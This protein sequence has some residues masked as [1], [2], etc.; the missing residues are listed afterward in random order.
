MSSR[1]RKTFIITMW[2]RTGIRCASRTQVKTGAIT[3][4]AVAKSR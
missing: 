4:S 1:T 2:M 3:A